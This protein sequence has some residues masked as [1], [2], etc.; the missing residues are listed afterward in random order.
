MA[1]PKI[2]LERENV[3]CTYSQ[4]SVATHMES[5]SSLAQSISTGRC[6]MLIIKATHISEHFIL[7]LEHQSQA[8][9]Y[10]LNILI[11]QF[12]ATWSNVNIGQNLI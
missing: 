4:Q 5:T 2:Y 10:Q 7:R 3:T 6:K 11:E 1:N 9:I 12:H 8:A